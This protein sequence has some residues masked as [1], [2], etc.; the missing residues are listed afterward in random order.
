MLIVCVMREYVTCIDWEFILLPVLCDESFFVNFRPLSINFWD[1]SMAFL[2]LFLLPSMFAATRCRAE[3]FPK[4]TGTV[5]S[6]SSESEPS[7]DSPSLTLLVLAVAD[8]PCS[9]RSSAC[10]YRPFTMANNKGVNPFKTMV[11]AVPVLVGS[12]NLCKMFTRSPTDAP[13]SSN[14]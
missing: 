1:K 7:E 6:S 14:F 3:N 9:K 5:S 11:L 13:A 2:L 10:S 8:A 12:V 4:R